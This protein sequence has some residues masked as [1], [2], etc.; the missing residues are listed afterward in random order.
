MATGVH[1]LRGRLAHHGTAEL[2]GQ[3]RM[4]LHD[5]TAPLD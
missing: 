3:I 2:H 1:R 5:R 4:P